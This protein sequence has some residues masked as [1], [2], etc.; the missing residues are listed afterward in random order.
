MKTKLWR[1]SIDDD[2]NGYVD[3]RVELH[4][5]DGRNVNLREPR[6]VPL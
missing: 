4:R 5:R 2:R 6:V 1:G 3:P